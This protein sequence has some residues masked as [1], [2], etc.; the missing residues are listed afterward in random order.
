MHDGVKYSFNVVIAVHSSRLVASQNFTDWGQ[1]SRSSS[2]RASKR[3][4]L[5]FLYFSISQS[6]SDITFCYS[7]GQFLPTLIAWLYKNGVRSVF[8]ALQC[9]TELQRKNNHCQKWNHVSDTPIVNWSSD[10]EFITVCVMLC[11]NTGLHSS[12]AKLNT[13][14]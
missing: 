13:M 14:I 10:T 1:F 11:C 2:A 3:Q 4:W 6:C 9:I 7:T 5:I 12:Y 8:D